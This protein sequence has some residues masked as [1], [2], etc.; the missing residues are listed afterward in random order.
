[1][2][3]M[4]DA[5]MDVKLFNKLAGNLDNVTMESIDAQISFCFE[6]LAETIT[7]FEEGD[8]SNFVKEVCDLNV[9]VQGLIQ[10]LVASGVNMEN[11]LKT[12]NENN[13]TKFPK[14]LVETDP[15][16]SAA[17]RG[18]TVVFNE[19]HSRYML[20]DSVG[21]IKKPTTYVAADMN[22]VA[23]GSLV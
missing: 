19:Q 2:Y 23:L 1:M 11:A 12:V 17:S 7:S 6:E 4:N 8:M 10:K 15:D 5:Y 22:H 18:L 21:K 20:K 14:T 9:V 13:L 16:G 3:T